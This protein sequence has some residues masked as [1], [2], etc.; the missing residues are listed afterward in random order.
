VKKEGRVHGCHGD[1]FG[2]GCRKMSRLVTGRVT[3]RC[4]EKARLYWFV[5]VSR[6][7]TPK[8]QLVDC[9]ET[10][11]ISVETLSRAVPRSKVLRFGGSGM[12]DTGL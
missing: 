5:T 8:G 7:W 4:S 9:G 2:T 6:L 1:G 12:W 11:A 3:G 10:S